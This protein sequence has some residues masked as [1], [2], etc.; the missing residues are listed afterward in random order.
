MKIVTPRDFRNA[1]VAVMKAEHASFRAA[2]QFEAKSYAYFM[3]SDILSKVARHL[4][5]LA[6]GKEYCTL[7]GV[8]YEERETQQP[9][10]N[11]M[12]AKW[13]SVALEHERD[14]RTTYRAMNKLQ[15]FNVPLKVLITYSTEG[16]ETE[17]LL[18]SY[19]RIIRAADVFDDFAT[20]RRQL[21]IVGSPGSVREWRF[22][23]YESD[24][25]VQ[26]LPSRE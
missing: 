4:G 26:M 15:L 11:A 16:A 20:L 24:G 2:V 14:P 8:F 19:E 17:S 9:R 23:A 5:L 21:V 3:R 7:E 12:Y 10:G 1:F 18:R 6:W 25:F 22:F 13:I